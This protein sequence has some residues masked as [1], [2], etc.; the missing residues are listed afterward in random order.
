MENN[1]EKPQIL[2]INPMGV[3]VDDVPVT[4]YNGAQIENI[5]HYSRCLTD[6]IIEVQLMQSDAF[7]RYG[8]AGNPKPDVYG[9]YLWMRAKTEDNIWSDWL[10]RANYSSLQKGIQFLPR[11]VIADASIMTSR[12]R[13]DFHN[14]IMSN[15]NNKKVKLLSNMGR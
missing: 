11:W 6:T 10:F 8:I 12:R 1:F 15:I 3:F 13:S 4:H 7:G 2:T 9:R 14:A 5:D